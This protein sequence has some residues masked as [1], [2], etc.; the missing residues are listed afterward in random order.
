MVDDDKASLKQLALGIVRAQTNVYIKELL[1]DNGVRIGATKDD[2]ER[3]MLEA[4]EDGNLTKVQLES[5][6]NA[7][8]G[9]GQ[10]HVYAYRLPPA[11]KRTFEA[12]G[13]AE[14]AI[15]DAGLGAH[16]GGS[17]TS[18]VEWPEDQELHLA[19]ITYDGSLRFHWHKGTKYWI[20][21][22]GEEQ[23]DKDP[24]WIDGFEYQFRAFRGRSV[25]EVMRFE[26]RPQ[27]DMAALFIPKAINSP[28]HQA[29]IATAKE[30]VGHVLDY[31]TLE[32][33]HLLVG[34]IIRN[35]DQALTFGSSDV[36]AS[37]QVSRLR[38]GAAYVEFGATST[39]GSYFDSSDVKVVREVI[40]S[41][42]D[43]S[44][45]D[46]TSGTF[47]FTDL[48]RVELAASDDRIRLWSS[49]TADS[50]WWILRTLRD[51]EHD[52]A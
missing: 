36:K 34:R 41:E 15:K 32:R 40:R 28:E 2:F 25:R 12:A 30:V 20:R 26:I 52:R 23:Y 51:F 8:E 5:W 31:S 29:A 10:Q 43:V 33:Q 17:T 19:A 9:W 46:G 44:A 35:F 3:N 7:V 47:R 39:N 49:L 21:T 1:R 48:G 42:K 6:L 24:E 22:K 14:A 45:F 37:P 38:S 50:V 4:I 11:I 18:Q 27:D 13:K 16:W